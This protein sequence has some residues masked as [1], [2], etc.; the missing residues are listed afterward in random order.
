MGKKQKK[1]FHAA[2][3]LLAA[4][5]FIFGS[6]T[7]VYAMDARN[8]SGGIYDETEYQGSHF[9]TGKPIVVTGEIDARQTVRN[10]AGTLVLRVTW[11]IVMRM[12]G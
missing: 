4:L 1:C 8:N 5:A 12:P 6:A 10:S 2:I 3:G 11:K 9:L 7:T